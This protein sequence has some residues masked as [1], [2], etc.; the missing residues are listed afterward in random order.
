MDDGMVAARS[1]VEDALIWVEEGNQVE[2]CGPVEGARRVMAACAAPRADQVDA[3][4]AWLLE[5]AAVAVAAAAA[6]RAGR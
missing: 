4:V 5:V 3:T 1:V 6:V 2:A